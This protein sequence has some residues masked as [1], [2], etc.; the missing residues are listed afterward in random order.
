M[1]KL[2]I[3]EY[4]YKRRWL[5]LPATGSLTFSIAESHCRGRARSDPSS[6]RYRVAVYE[7]VERKRRSKP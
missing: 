6:T 7:R 3:V 2:Y 4:L 1:S 5:A